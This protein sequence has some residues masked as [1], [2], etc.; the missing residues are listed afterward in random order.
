MGGQP[1]EFRKSNRPVHAVALNRG[2]DAARRGIRRRDYCCLG[3]ALT[4]ELK[5]EYQ[6]PIPS[7]SSSLTSPR[8]GPTRQPPHPH[9][10]IPTKWSTRPSAMTAGT[11]H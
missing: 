10:Q 11:S 1:K 6:A 3:P 2:G 8:P 7:I 4:G 5:A 9:N